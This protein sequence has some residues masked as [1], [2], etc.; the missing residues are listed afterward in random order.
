MRRQSY[1]AVFEPNGD[2][3]YGVYFPDIGGCTSFGHTYEEA[4]FM[5]QEALGVHLYEMEKDGDHIPR[6]TLD[7]AK[8][9][10]EPETTGGYIIS[11]ITV[12]PDIVKDRLDNRSVKTTITLPAWLKELAEARRVNF[13]HLLQVSLKEHLR[14]TEQ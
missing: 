2:G 10:I 12:Y 6:A 13:S 11:S 9:D 1:F 4:E 14:I 8:L 5:A 7:P 3:G